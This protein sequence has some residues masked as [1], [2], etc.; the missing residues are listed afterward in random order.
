M[1]LHRLLELS[2]ARAELADRLNETADMNTL[3]GEQTQQLV[4]VVVHVI[5]LVLGRNADQ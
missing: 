1:T 3:L 4:R 5:Q 2:Q